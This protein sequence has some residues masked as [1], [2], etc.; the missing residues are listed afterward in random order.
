MVP[1]VLIMLFCAANLQC[2]QF[3][4]DL[5]R[6]GG[7]RLKSLAEVRSYTRL[8]LSERD[9]AAISDECIASSFCFDA[10]RDTRLVPSPNDSIFVFPEPPITLS[11][12]STC[13]S[14]QSCVNETVTTSTPAGRS[15]SC[16][17]SEDVLGGKRTGE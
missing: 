12:T 4:F 10:S 17:T 7:A 1:S 15:V 13:T 11:S 14:S 5:F 6:P 8:C 2:V 9:A 3:I 16:L